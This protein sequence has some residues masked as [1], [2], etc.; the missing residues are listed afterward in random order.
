MERTDDQRETAFH[1]AGHAVV[2]FLLGAPFEEAAI[3]T[4]PNGEFGACVALGK[5]VLAEHDLCASFGGLLAQAFSART[6][7]I[8]FRLAADA[9]LDVRGALRALIWMYGTRRK[10][11]WKA[12]FA[13]MPSGE[14]TKSSTY[15]NFQKQFFAALEQSHLPEPK[16]IVGDSVIFCKLHGAARQARTLLEQNMELLAALGNKLLEV[17]KMSR[18]ELLAFLTEQQ[19][20]KS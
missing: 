3:T 15:R 1:E 14:K 17:K 8:G 6:D 13:S 9:G 11:L 5:D 12:F 19:S 16:T 18:D 4:E 2:G 20:A 10:R 7:G